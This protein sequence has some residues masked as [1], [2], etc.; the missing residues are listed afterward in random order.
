MKMIQNYKVWIN[1]WNKLSYKMNNNGFK[2]Y[3]K[4]TN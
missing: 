2:V 1:Q 4:I 3:C